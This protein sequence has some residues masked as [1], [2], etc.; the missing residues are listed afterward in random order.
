MMPTN[1]R[2]EF[3]TLAEYW[4]PKVV[5]ELNGQYL[6]IAKIKGEFVWH[7]HAGEDE[8]FWVVKGEM[9]LRFRDGAV[10]LKE[11]EFFIVPKGVE[12]NPRAGDECWVVLLEPKE[13][14]HTGARKT[15]LTKSIEEQRKN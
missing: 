4:S 1:I 12:H 5:G 7:D 2:K 14:L 8:L 13:T 3:K 9:E 10:R 6:K 11:G 15:A